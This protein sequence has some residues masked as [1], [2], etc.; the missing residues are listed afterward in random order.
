MGKVFR[1]PLWATGQDEASVNA[2]MARCPLGKEEAEPGPL[3]RV[4]LSQVLCPT[5]TAGLWQ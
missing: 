5:R 1:Y 2:A 4:D 3:Q